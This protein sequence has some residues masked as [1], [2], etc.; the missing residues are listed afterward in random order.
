M[1]LLDR[2]LQAVKFWLPKAQKQDITAE[3]AE[4]IH[5]YIDE[6]EGELGRALD[7]AE[8]AA[9]LKR[10]GPPVFVA[11]RCL[12]QRHLIGP[13]LFPIYRFV[14]KLVLFVYLVPWLVVWISLVAFV[15]SYRAAHP[16]PELIKTLSTWWNLA[17]YLFGMITVGFAVADRIQAKS[18]FLERWDPRKLPAVRDRSRISRATSISELVTD[19]LFALWWVGVLRF[20]AVYINEGAR[21]LWTPG[22]VWQTFHQGFYAPILLLLLAGMAMACFNLVR[23]RWTRLRLGIRAAINGIAAVLLGLVLHAHWAEVYAQ[24]MAVTSRAAAVPKTELLADWTNITIFITLL[25]A[26]VICFSSCLY[27]VFRIIRLNE[28][29]QVTHKP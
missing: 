5:S 9:V 6:K 13:V 26:A 15:P 12:P 3:L 21:V 19:A 16:G 7:D 25:I 27:H 14:L 11:E 28:G 4:D 23:P 17:F 2:Y 20:P 24:W 18:K 10:Y 22:P 8:L 1:E 29:P